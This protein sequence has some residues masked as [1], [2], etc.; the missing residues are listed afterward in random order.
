MT[1]LLSSMLRYRQPFDNH[2]S[3]IWQNYT[4]D[5]S[6]ASIW[7]F[8][9]WFIV[10][11]ACFWIKKRANCS[12]TFFKRAN[13]SFSLFLYRA[14]SERAN[15]EPCWGQAHYWIVCYDFWAQKDKTL[16]FPNT[17]AGNVSFR[18]IVCYVWIG[19]HRQ[20]SFAEYIQHNN[21][22]CIGLS[23]LIII[24]TTSAVYEANY[25]GLQGGVGIIK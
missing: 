6:K 7:E 12:C 1:L 8:A 25:Q 3:T 18:I 5:W 21:W 4:V 17:L 2:S 16:I 23:N 14:K 22:Q 13:H 19:W 11:I 20:A 15:S 9:P 24:I 10:G